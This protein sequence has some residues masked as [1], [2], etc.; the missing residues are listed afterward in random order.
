[1]NSSGMTL[2][3]GSSS[4]RAAS[5]R[6]KLAAQRQ[7]RAGIGVEN[8][9]GHKPSNGSPLKRSDG[10]MNLSEA[11]RG[12]P[13]AK[14]RSQVGVGLFSSMNKAPTFGSPSFGAKSSPSPKRQSGFKKNTGQVFGDKPTWAKSR[15][16]NRTE[17]MPPSNPASRMRRVTSVENFHAS[18]DSPFGNQVAP[19]ANPSIHLFNGNPVN[20]P[21]PLSQTFNQPTPQTSDADDFGP[22]SQNSNGLVTPQNYKTAKPFP[23]AFH[24]TGFVPKRGRLLNQEK[25]HGPQ[26]DTPCKK[27]IG[28]PIFA[29]S[30][31]QSK[32]VMGKS[33]GL[34]MSMTEFASTSS[35]PSDSGTG[36]WKLLA[37]KTSSMS[38][39]DGED[40]SSS[41]EY[42][43]PPTPT[44]KFTGGLFGNSGNVGGNGVG[45]NK[46]LRTDTS[47]KY[48]LRPQLDKK[49]NTALIAEGLRG[50]YV[51][52]TPH[53]PRENIVPPDL[54]SVSISG[55][56]NNASKNF[57]PATPSPSKENFPSFMFSSSSTTTH[58]VQSTDGRTVQVSDNF[59][60][61]F[62][63]VKHIGS[64]QFSEVYQV[65]Q[66]PKRHPFI[67]SL[68][69]PLT[70]HQ[71][72][73]PRGSSIYGSSPL[74]RSPGTGELSTAVYAVKKSKS[75][76]HGDNAR[77]RRM[78][79]AD[80]LKELGQ[81]DHVVEFFGSWEDEGHLYIQ[82]EFCENGS[83]DKFLEQHGD[84]GRL[85][86]FRVWKVLLELCSVSFVLI[87]EM[88]LC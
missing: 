5:P 46:R 49:S 78:E 41:G 9:D 23:A 50:R 11:S 75:S 63:E 52:N 31:F 24:S 33:R 65:T 13:V 88:I 37:R 87:H 14:R 17:F 70:P 57:L 83:L 22:S 86:E 47:G 73:T 39:D 80:I 51:T 20:N 28:P 53:T 7:N 55:R 60:K 45:G 25:D 30:A 76:L 42:E 66:G 21:H 29:H 69:P 72:A 62:S 81:H 48:N 6:D 82:T 68:D 34:S 79:E 85:D 64:G 58:A 67:A 59:V 74:P 40:L 27:P 38:N 71:L 8:K 32:G 2:R 56:A 43:L 15:P 12:S 84:K 54:S 16:Q 35:T 44:K 36:R 19:L 26:P 18:R 10:I 4:P 77:A 1:M 61:R 3:S